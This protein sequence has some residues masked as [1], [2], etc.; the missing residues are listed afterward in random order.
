MGKKNAHRMLFEEGWTPTAAEAKE[1]GIVM[2]VVKHENLMPRAQ[3]IAEGWVKS[4]KVRNLVEQ[5]KM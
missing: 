2:E 5:G 1:A 3:E 4:N